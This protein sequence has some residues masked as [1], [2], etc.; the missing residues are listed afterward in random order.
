MLSNPQVRYHANKIVDVFDKIIKGLTINGFSDVVDLNRLGKSHFYYEVRRVDF[1][2]FE[3]SMV[4]S[5]K[6]H[7]IDKKLFNAKAEKAWHKA[8]W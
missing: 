7:T 8:F 1:K 5:L 2:H 6:K 4:F 3:E